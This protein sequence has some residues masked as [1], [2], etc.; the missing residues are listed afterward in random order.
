MMFLPT[1]MQA[2][3]IENYGNA[4]ALRNKEVSIPKIG[5]DE[6]LIRMQSAGVSPFDIHVR[7]G[8]YKDEYYAL[9]I[10]L[11]W[12]LSG[13][14]AAVGADTA[15]F[16]IGDAIF[17]YPAG[18]RAGSS[19]AQYNAIKASE[20]VHKPSTITHHQA[21]AA[22]MNAIT[23]WQ[24]L[25]DAANIQSGQRVLIQAAAGGIGHLAVQL[26][27]WKGAY[28]IGTA[29]T[30][31]AE[32]LKALGVDEFVDY[33]KVSLAEAI[34]PVDAVIDTMGGDVLKQSFAAVKKG[35][36]IVTLIDFEGIKSADEYG[37]VGKTVFGTPNQVQLQQIAE[38]LAQGILKPH[39]EAIFPLS[40]VQQAH[41]R[42]ESGHTRGKIVLAIE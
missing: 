1:H 40:Q 9:P 14:V 21:A 38:L 20:A 39:V 35:G 19:Y 31:N 22:T 27:K 18:H 13:I 15:G 25:F 28:V 10:I 33:T 5:A 16:Q 6:L 29:S 23:A 37:V 8:W 17:A 3:V 36:T 2:V 32:F 24:A 26:A 4:D 34:M 11:G 7:D 41:Q 12:E 30:H 42:V